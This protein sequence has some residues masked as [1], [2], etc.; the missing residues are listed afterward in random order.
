VWGCFVVLRWLV[1]WQGLPDLDTGASATQDI[2][3]GYFKS[4]QALGVEGFRID[5]AKHQDDQQVKQHSS[6]LKACHTQHTHKAHKAH[7]LNT[8]APAYRKLSIS[9]LVINH[10]PLP[11]PAALLPW[12]VLH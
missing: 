8:H 2:L 4:L 3:A 7:T 11:F 12:S 9:R 1:G 5:A 10:F 6:A